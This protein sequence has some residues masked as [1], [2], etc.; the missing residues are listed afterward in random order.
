ME[1]LTPDKHPLGSTAKS[2]IKAIYGMKMQP[3]KDPY[4]LLM[5]KGIEACNRSLTPGAHLVDVLP[6]C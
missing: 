3:H 4:V 1:V 5:E 6:T 2:L